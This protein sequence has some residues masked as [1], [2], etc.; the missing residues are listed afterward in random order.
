MFRI[1]EGR[2]PLSSF[3]SLDS[4]LFK[5][6][7]SS[8]CKSI[9]YS[10][11]SNEGKLDLTETSF[12]GT[13]PKLPP[14]KPKQWNLV[15]FSSLQ[16]QK[17]DRIDKN[18]Q[19]EALQPCTSEVKPVPC[20]SGAIGVLMTVFKR[21][22]RKKETNSCE[23]GKL[24]VKSSAVLGCGPAFPSL[25]A[26]ISTPGRKH[27]VWEDSAFIKDCLD[28]HNLLRARHG[29]KQLQLDPALCEM[30]YSWATFL[31]SINEFYHQNSEQHGENLF[32]W[33]K[34]YLPS[35][36]TLT[37]N[38]CTEVDGKFVAIHWYRDHC[39][40]PYT[41]PVDILHSY[42]S[43]FTQMV[44][45]S[46]KLFGVGRAKGENGKSIIVAYY[47]PK[48]NIPSKFHLNVVQPRKFR[49]KIERIKTPP[50]VRLKL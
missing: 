5:S 4:D 36:S 22:K 42:S 13:Y 12:Y 43:E 30:A 24:L 6:S 10:V 50:K 27:T 8:L 44:W 46:T 18:N 17:N 1:E 38:L 28:W 26:G 35:S 16:T 11:A 19:K 21:K 14:H 39:T 29:V 47:Y 40:Y 33:P 15:Y 31:T 49:E 34:Q 23:S 37:R 41:K 20:K 2:A 9:K 48:G 32:L 25:V 3:D 45:A 7:T